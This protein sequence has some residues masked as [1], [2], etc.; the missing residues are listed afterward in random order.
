MPTYLTR[1]W[2]NRWVRLAVVFAVVVA[3]SLPLAWLFDRLLE[4]VK[5]DLA[6][7]AW[8]AYLVVFGAALAANLTVVAP[9][10]VFMPIMVAAAGIYNP[11]LI[12]LS[13]A[14]GGSIGEMG[15]Y[16]AG[17]VGKK[18]VFND[19][20]EAYEKISSWVDRYGALAIVILAFQPILPFDVA[21]IV[22]GATRMRASKFWVACFV[23]KFAKYVLV[24]YFYDVMKEHLP[25]IG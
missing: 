23:G 1:L 8:L 17:T 18:I 22:A 24:C 13:A 15:G 25:F 2:K 21:G 20:P 10:Y 12:A 16:F 14:L 6:Q 7:Y 4:P 11:A 3:V 5:D 19:Y 9:V